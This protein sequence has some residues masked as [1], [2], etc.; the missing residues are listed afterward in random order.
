[1]PIATAV[2]EYLDRKHVNY[3]VLMHP[4]TQN[5][6]HTAELAHVPGDQ[7]AKAVVLED[8]N[9]YLMAVLAASHKLDLQALGRELQRDGLTFA[10]ERELITLFKDC[11]R[12]AVPPLGPSYDIETVLDRSLA[13]APEIYF[14]A[15]DHLTLI[16]LKGV[17]FRR[18]MDDVPQRSISHHL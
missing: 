8:D 4:P 11:E 12:G 6:A 14:E 7:L 5:A 18:L 10:D 13:D 17:E 15:G 3:D 1:M 2:R 9:G 16:R